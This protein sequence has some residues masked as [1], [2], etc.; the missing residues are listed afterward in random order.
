MRSASSSASTN[1]DINSLDDVNKAID[2]VLGSD[3]QS[4]LQT[5]EILSKIMEIAP[6][7]YVKSIAKVMKGTFL[8]SWKQSYTP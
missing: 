2:T 6:S 7:E 4:S 5:R 3:S 8:V 1:F